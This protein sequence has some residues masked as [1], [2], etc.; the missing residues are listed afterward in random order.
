MRGSGEILPGAVRAFLN[1]QVADIV[2]DY[3]ILEEA[4]V[5]GQ[6]NCFLT[7]TGVGNPDW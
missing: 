2:E 1:F 3:N 7:L 4:R 5:R 6:S